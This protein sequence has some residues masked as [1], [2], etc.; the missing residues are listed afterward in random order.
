[1]RLRALM[2]GVDDLAADLGA[3]SSRAGRELT[4]P[5][6]IARTMCL[7]AAAQA[8]VDAIDAVSTKLGDE[9]E[10]EDEAARAR[11]DG[12]AAKAAG[13]PS[14]IAA[15]NRAFLPKDEEVAW[16]RKVVA[17]FSSVGAS[18]VYA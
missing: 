17:A 6:S 3:L 14:H 7:L 16:A 18:G 4:S 13:H 15:I 12:F 5:F 2:W 11:R 1:M 9:A 10:I 8:G